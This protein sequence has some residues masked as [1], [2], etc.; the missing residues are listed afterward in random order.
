MDKPVRIDVGCGTCK[1]SDEYIGIDKVKCKGVDIV[2]D[3]DNCG[4]PLGNETAEEIYT[5]HFLE[6]CSN[7][8]FV[9]KEFY[10]VLNSGGLLRIRV[11]HFTFNAA[12]HDPT[13]KRFFGVFTFDYFVVNSDYPTWYTDAKFELKSRKLHFPKSYALTLRRT[14]RAKKYFSFFLR[15]LFHI[16]NYLFN[17]VMEKIINISELSLLMYEHT[18]LRVFPAHEIEVVLRKI[19]QSDGKN[20]G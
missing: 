3:V 14:L 20:V 8:E 16:T 9:M 10:R 2:A 6:H 12:Y 11:P 5:S 15:F 13:H 7:L 17:T 18:C 4:L 19:G 1:I